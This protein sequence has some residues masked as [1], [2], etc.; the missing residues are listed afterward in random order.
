M[1]ANR[2]EIFCLHAVRLPSPHSFL[3]VAGEGSGMGGNFT[4]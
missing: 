2:Y 3:R 4:H 1:I